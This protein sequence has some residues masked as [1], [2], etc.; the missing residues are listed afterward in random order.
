[1]S[2][3]E[4]L[5]QDLW[6]LEKIL[7][8]KVKHHIDVGSRLDG[9]VCQLAVSVKITYVDIRK[10]GFFH[11]N[12]NFVDG[13]ILNLPFADKSISS[14]S[15]L[16]VVEHIGLGRYFD[17]LDPMGTIKALKELKRVVAIDGDLYLGVPV[18]RE[19]VEFNANR[20]LH[21]LTIYSIFSKDCELIEFAYAPKGE[22]LRRFEDI[23][24]FPEIDYAIGLFHFRH[25]ST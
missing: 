5:I 17:D 21:P 11:P 10:P 13:S 18:G 3:N 14:L 12:F 24:N 9:F 1:M 19:R 4:Y 22:S 7:S 6:A 8:S 20:I 25:R 15:S 23:D 16:H 2:W